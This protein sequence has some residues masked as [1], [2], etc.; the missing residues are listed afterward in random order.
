MEEWLPDID[1]GGGNGSDGASDNIMRH[2]EMDWQL[3]REIFVKR[4]VW[5]SH[6]LVF[7]WTGGDFQISM[8]KSGLKSLVAVELR[9]KK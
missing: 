9:L 8:P 2:E 5:S 1:W 6:S 3:E 4:Y 7:D